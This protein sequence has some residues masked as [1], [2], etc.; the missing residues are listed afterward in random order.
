[1]FFVTWKDNLLFPHHI[2]KHIHVTTYHINEFSFLSKT[3]IETNSCYAIFVGFFF[4]LVYILHL[5]EKKVSYA[6]VIFLET[7]NF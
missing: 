6:T 7:E 5:I 4:F 1:V 2:V 3:N